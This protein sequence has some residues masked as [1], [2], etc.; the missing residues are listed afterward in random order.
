[1]KRIDGDAFSAFETAAKMET[2]CQI[3]LL[4]VH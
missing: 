3:H 1:M 4:Y 2:G